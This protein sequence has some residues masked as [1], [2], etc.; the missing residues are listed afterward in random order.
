MEIKNNYEDI[1]KVKGRPKGAPGFSKKGLVAFVVGTAALAGLAVA[2]DYLLR[3][4]E[5]DY[6]KA[7]DAIIQPYAEKAERTCS[8]KEMRLLYESNRFS[9]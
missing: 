1:E 8:E 9:E 7:Q 2:G 5:S 4:I 6:Y 3:P